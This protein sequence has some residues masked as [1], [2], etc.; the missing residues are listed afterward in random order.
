MPTNKRETEI[1]MDHVFKNNENNENLKVALDI[2]SRTQEIRSRIIKPFLEKLKSFICEELDMSQWDW[3]TKLNKPLEGKRRFGVSSKF[4]VLKEPVGILLKGYRADDFYIGV[5]S[6]PAN[7]SVNNSMILRNQLTQELGASGPPW[8][9]KSELWI[10]Y[11]PLS[12]SNRDYTDWTN[13]HTLIKMHT[14]PD[15]V[16][17][18]IGNHLLRIINVAKPEIE[19]WVRQNPPS[20]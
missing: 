19:K 17:E 1:I 7:I 18:D 20:Q 15:R 14:D 3:E 11:Q 9:T 6:P 13:K 10:W 5:C 8:E 2:I 4:G 12:F 16:V